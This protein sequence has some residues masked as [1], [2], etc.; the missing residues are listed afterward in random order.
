DHTAFPADGAY[1]WR[2]DR[3]GLRINDAPARGSGG[4]PVTVR[5]IWEQF[6]TAIANW[7][8]RLSVPAELIIA[9]ILTESS[10]KANAI[11]FEPRYISDEATPNQVSPG[12]MQTL[13]STARSVLA[14]P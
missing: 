3:T 8:T 2:I 9:T 4:P 6:G 1:K 14:N 5:A 12:L 13:I 10:G 11:R 7:S